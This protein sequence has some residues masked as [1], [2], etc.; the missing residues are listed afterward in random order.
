MVT[1]LPREA[2]WGETA[3]NA[4]GSIAGAASTAHAEQADEQILRSAVEKLGPNASMKDTLMA[5]TN[6]KTYR[7]ESKTKKLDMYSK[8]YGLDL[9]E[10]AINAKNEATRQKANAQAEKQDRQQRETEALLAEANPDLTPEQIK[11]KAKNLSPASARSLITKPEVVTDY[12]IAQNQAKRFD[13][14]I[15]HYA[16]KTIQNRSVMPIIETAI[17]N[18][19][20][21]T[22]SEK[23]WD[24][25]LDIGGSMWS[26]LKSK[27]GQELEAITPISMSGFSQKMGGVLTNRKIDM[28]SK[29][30]AG[31]GKDKNANR[32]LLYLDYAD[33]KMDELYNQIDNEILRESKYG[34][35]PADFDLQVQERIKP[36]QKMINAD[37]DLL[38]RDQKPRSPILQTNV[39]NQLFENTPKGQVPVVSPE[40]VAGYLSEEE[41]KSPEFKRFRRLY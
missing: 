40:G 20:E 6:A 5:I 25:F 19:E 9:Q 38:L 22:D 14:E 15:K 18:N 16:E 30:A 23:L 27:R 2:S 17:I 32:L 37:I 4:L 41:L 26:P 35:A 24:N 39:R 1:V 21:Y 29:K 10:Q 34:L 36:F 13:P 8:S 7:P 12:K 28:I 11:D 31:I 33:K 3:A